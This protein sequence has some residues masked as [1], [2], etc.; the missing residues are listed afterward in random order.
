MPACSAGAVRSRLLAMLAGGHKGIELSREEMEK[1]A[2]WIDLGVPFC[3]DYLQANAWTE[4]EQARYAHF[5]AKRQAAEANE[6]GEIGLL[7]RERP[8]VPQ[9]PG[10]P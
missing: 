5:L 3:G 6:A 9:P 7:A 4:A 1:L 10:P 8:L 2:C